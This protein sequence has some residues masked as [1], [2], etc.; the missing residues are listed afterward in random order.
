MGGQ[1]IIAQLR[2]QEIEGGEYFVILNL[3]KNMPTTMFPTFRYR[4]QWSAMTWFMFIFL[5]KIRQR[6]LQD[7]LFQCP[8]YIASHGWFEA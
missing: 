3:A 2:L 8:F 7:R 5:A 6:I 4:E 1:P